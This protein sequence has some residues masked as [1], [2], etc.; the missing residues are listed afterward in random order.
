MDVSTPPPSS[1]A[2]GPSLPTPVADPDAK[3]EQ[4]A[5]LIPPAVAGRGRGSKSL[6]RDHPSDR[7]GRTLSVPRFGKI[8]PKHPLAQGISYPQN[9]W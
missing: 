5:G 9:R 1:P 8:L 7:S 4:F 6:S 3:L 2:V